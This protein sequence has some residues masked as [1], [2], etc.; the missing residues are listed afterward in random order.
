MPDGDK[1][2]L[3]AAMIQ[4]PN[5]AIQE[6]TEVTAGAVRGSGCKNDGGPLW[7]SIPIVDDPVVADEDGGNPYA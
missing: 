1:L 2:C 4:D 7:I 5:V 3:T 6:I